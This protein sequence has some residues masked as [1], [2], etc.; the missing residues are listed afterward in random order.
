MNLFNLE[1]IKRS[2][3]VLFSIVILVGC[4][5]KGADYEGTLSPYISLEDIRTIYKG[6]EIT[7]TESNLNGAQKI[8]GVVI[9][10]HT[11][12]NLP[13]GLVVL[14]QNR[15]GRI[16][17]ISLKMGNE[18][19]NYQVGDSLVVNIV[20]KKIKK[21]G[22]LFI[23]NVN[24]QDVEIIQRNKDIIVRK[25]TSNLLKT[26]SEEYESTLVTILG[27]EMLPKPTTETVL[28]GEKIL[29]NGADSVMVVTLNTA[30]FKD[31]ILPR[32]INITGIALN[33]D[34]TTGVQNGIFPRKLEDIVDVS[35][36]EIPGDL[37]DFPIII[38]GFCNDPSGS[39]SNNE[40]IQL[41]ANTDIDFSEIPFSVVTSNNAGVI[42]HTAGWATGQARTFKFN[43]TTGKV[44]KGDYFYVGG[45]SKRINGGGSTL[46]SS[47]NWIRSISTANGAS[48]D[49]IGTSNANLLPNSG[50]AGGIALF[51][52]TNITEKS[53]PIDVIFF[54]GNETASI[55]NEDKTLG[56]RIGNTD[57]YKTYN[58]ENGLL[59]PFFS[60]GNGINDFRFPHHGGA[61]TAPN[62]YF[63]K[64][65]GQF[66]IKDRKWIEP[67]NATIIT[68]SL[69]SVL[70]DIETGEGITIQE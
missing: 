47:A 58:T 37:G 7:L 12:G 46:I 66:S 56:Y 9:S 6:E 68:M 42:L 39:D 52:G 4:E 29:Q 30:V 18:A 44:K 17:G 22:Y 14:Q 60:M 55:I 45:T 20:E 36:P 23:D 51:V 11:G 1:Y 5:D 41:K 38:T 57:H 54:G 26:K 24:N 69:E 64:L 13:N 59:S 10:D 35:D 31:E 16:R 43:L 62:G 67:R 3:V 49:G 27:G 63:Y 32:N 8:T 40:Y 33:L 19:K 70:S 28:L 61:T 15:K 2:L 65:G 25:T 53:I 50:N 21:N 48:G 34:N